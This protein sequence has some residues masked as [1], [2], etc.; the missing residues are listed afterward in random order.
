MCL[1]CSVL[2]TD[3]GIAVAQG[4]KLEGRSA[5]VEVLASKSALVLMDPFG[6]QI[7]QNSARSHSLRFRLGLASVAA[8]AVVEVAF[9]VVVS[10]LVKVVF[11]RVVSFECPTIGSGS[12]SG[13]G[14]SSSGSG[15]SSSRSRSS[16]VS[17][18]SSSS[19]SS[20]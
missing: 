1:C 13:G 5:S 11:V 14:S 16:S 17:S 7:W 18:S 8:V 12:G 3:F 2:D 15:S 19:A 10:V 6:Q 4:V 20:R 9:V